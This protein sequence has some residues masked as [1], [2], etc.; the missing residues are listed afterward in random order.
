MLWSIVLTSSI[1]LLVGAFFTYKN[2]KIAA[3][4]SLKMQ[5][6]GIAITV[7]SF[8]QSLELEEIKVL[9]YALFSEIILN[10][11]WEGVAFISL[12][13][14]KGNIILH[15]NPELIGK[16]IELKK[17]PYYPYYYYLILGTLEKVFVTD[18]KI[19]FPQGNY[20]IL[21]VAL[22]T[23]PA[24]LM[25]GKAKIFVLINITASIGLIIFGILGTFLVRK[26][27]RMQIKFKEL[28]SISLMTKILAHEIRNPLG[29]IKGFSQ[30]L[31]GRVDE[32]FK[33]PLKIIFNETL[34]I[35][36]L[37]DELLFYTN[38]VKINLTEFFLSELLEEI[39][40][41]FK[42]TYPEIDFKFNLNNEIKVKSDRDKLKEI[43]I[44][45]LQNA[46]DAVLEANKEK[47]I[48][49]LNVEKRENKIKFEI[50]D[51]G[52][53]MDK[54]TLEKATEPFFTTKPKGSGLGLAIVN[55]L[56]EALSIKLKIE[57]KKGDGTRVCLIIPELP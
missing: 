53:G 38:P 43:I 21:R 36:R 49:S 45:L 55:K 28:E 23:Y 6:M 56:C 10:E 50:I 51:N 32:K 24:E 4:N 40:I 15:S 31:M 26:I 7:Q 19:N 9:D 22:H 25:I 27:E 48:V 34:R 30:Y 37:T 16:K 18:F 54:E 35:E 5:A 20:Y 12:Y 57:S 29:S 41:S 8:L 33:D 39:L 17:H 13:D 44:N 2:T 3:E 52:I 42:N 46:I 14:E 11:K 1:I 47:R